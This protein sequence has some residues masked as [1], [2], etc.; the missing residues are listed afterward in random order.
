MY[1]SSTTKLSGRAVSSSG[2]SGYAKLRAGIKLSSRI[3]VPASVAASRWCYTLCFC[4][5]TSFFCVNRNRRGV[6]DIYA[7]ATASPDTLPGVFRSSAS[8][9]AA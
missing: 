6:H 5:A 2:F 9:V 7:S 8:V 4:L 1:L 3:Q